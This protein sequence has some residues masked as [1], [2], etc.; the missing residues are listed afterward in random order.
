M[1]TMSNSYELFSY[2]EDALIIKE[3]GLNFLKSIKG[4]IILITII[5]SL[6]DKSQLTPIKLSLLSN[7]TQS[8][9]QENL[10]KN[11]IKLY[12][13]NLQK[14]DSKS[15]ILLLEMNCS[16]K[17]LFSLLFL[18]SSLFIFCVDKNIDDTELKK[19]VLINSLQNTIELKN[20]NNKVAF[21]SDCSPKL[22]FFLANNDTTLPKNYLEIQLNDQSGND[23][24][25]NT[26]K[27]NIIKLFPDR[28]SMLDDIKDNNKTLID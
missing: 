28:E 14:E 11:L 16:D 1:N 26:L 12:T 2:E 7:L 24:D 15:K 25:I 4:E 9:F 22:I 18:S 23:K 10:N 19:F 21:L 27:E 20:K 3:E 13:S 8:E 5:S 17:H 6:D